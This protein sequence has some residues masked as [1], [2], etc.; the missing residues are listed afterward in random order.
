MSRPKF[1]G[2]IPARG[3]SKGIPRKNIR[4]LHGKPLIAWTIEAALNA[5]SLDRVIVSTEDSEIAL[6]AKKWGAD[7]PF[8][9]P[10]SLAQDDTLRNGVVEHALQAVPGYDYVVLLQPTSP[11]RTSA[12]IDEAVDLLIRENASACVSVNKQHLSPHW[13]FHLDA[14]KKL[15]FI[16]PAPRGT[17]RQSVPEVFGLNGAVFICRSDTFFNS[18]SV[19]PFITADTVAYEM[20][21]QESWDI[22][23]EWEWGVIESLMSVGSEI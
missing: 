13:M 19:D 23:D 16:K 10:V 15:K 1:L 20:P 21:S 14:S 12:H 4:D 18:A 22:D 5:D 6:V 11:L 9:R 3:G 17:N 2:L 8:I 7:V